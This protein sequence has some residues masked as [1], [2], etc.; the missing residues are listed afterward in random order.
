VWFCTD[1]LREG[2]D[3]RQTDGARVTLTP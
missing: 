2:V 1:S 3:I